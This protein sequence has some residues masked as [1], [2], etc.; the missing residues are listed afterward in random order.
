MNKIGT[1]PSPNIDNK[2]KKPTD[3]KASMNRGIHVYAAEF[4]Q[5]LDNGHLLL[6]V[7]LGF[8]IR[9]E[10][11]FKLFVGED[12]FLYGCAWEAVEEWLS[13]T[14]YILIK[15]TRP[16]PGQFYADITFRREDGQWYNVA[17]LLNDN[18]LIWK[19]K[20]ARAKV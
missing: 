13:G 16:K 8:G 10:R 20:D 18:N 4:I 7:D 11:V 9:N 1:N 3:G 5:V 12:T 17:Q 19:G 15:T 2:K 14:E 6:D